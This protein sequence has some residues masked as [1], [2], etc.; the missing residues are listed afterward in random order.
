MVWARIQAGSAITQPP[1]PPEKPIASSASGIWA[2][3]MKVRIAGRGGAGPPRAGAQA[4]CHWQPW[5]L[6]RSRCG[7]GGARHHLRLMDDVG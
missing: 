2:N 3:I 4:V 5:L 6:P 1:P 7:C